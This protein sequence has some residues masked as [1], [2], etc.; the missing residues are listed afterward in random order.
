MARPSRYCYLILYPMMSL[1]CGLSHLGLKSLH[2]FVKFLSL[3]DSFEG[4]I[5]G[6]MKLQS[7][8]TSQPR[9]IVHQGYTS[10]RTISRYTIAKLLLSRPQATSYKFS[11]GK[12]YATRTPQRSK[13]QIPARCCLQQHST[14]NCHSSN[15]LSNFPIS[16]CTFVCFST[17]CSPC[18]QHI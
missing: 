8:T 18:R 10:Y 11:T 16:S 17:L 5:S 6:N 4:K 12:W 3:F 15:N 7:W 13:L 14:V 9:N 1:L 2:L